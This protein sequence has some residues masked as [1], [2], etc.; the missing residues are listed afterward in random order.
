MAQIKAVLFDLDDT[1]YDHRFSSRNGLRALKNVYDCFK[2]AELDVLEMEYLKLLNEIHL[3]KVLTGI[4]TIDEARAERYRRFFLKFGVDAGLEEINH[5]REIYTSAYRVIQ[6]AVPGSIELLNKLKKKV[7]LGI[8]SNN[9]G[10]EQEAKINSCGFN[11][12]FDAV[13]TSVEVGITKPSPEIFFMA[14]EKLGFMPAETVMIGDSW[15]SD[16]KGARNAGIN[17]IWFNRY[18]FD[19]PEENS[20][21]PEIRSLIPIEYVLSLIF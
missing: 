1:L 5:A 7:K 12:Y 13:V 11:R 3:S 9:Y 6:R 21:I 2:N 17:P 16:I 8:V 15:N 18:G 19:Y 14:L 10:T 20:N 4:Y